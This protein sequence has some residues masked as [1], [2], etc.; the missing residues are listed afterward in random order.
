MI[1]NN[2]GLLLAIWAGLASAA[3]ADLH[4]ENESLSEV[5]KVVLGDIAKV[6][7]ILTPE[8]NAFTDKVTIS[9]AKLEPQQMI[10]QVSRLLSEVGFVFSHDQGVIIVKREDNETTPFVYFPK[11]RSVEY[12]T[13][14]VKTMLPVKPI[15]SFQSEPQKDSTAD[16]Q[17]KT[18]NKAKPS[19]PPQPVTKKPSTPDQ[20]VLMVPIKELAK[21]QR[22]ISHLDQPTGEVLLKAAIYEVSTTKTDGSAIQLALS[23]AG[24]QAQAGNILAGNWAKVA[25][26]AGDIKLDLVLSALDQDTRFKSIAKPHVR[27]KNGGEAKFSVGQDVPILAGNQLDR[28]GN[29]IQQV[30]YKPSGIIL[31]ARPEIRKESIE[32]ELHQELSNFVTTTTGINNSPTLIKRSVDT[33]LSLQSGELVVL[34]GLQDNK[35][36]GTQNRMPFFNW[37]IGDQQRK[38]Q[39]EILVFIE[40]IKL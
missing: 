25:A 15:S 11:H 34:A 18:E 14:I 33:Q 26:R 2:L 24:L 21:V 37:L 38:E 1:K 28:N 7:Y 5:A 22:L 32:L 36:D 13:S 30:E 31:R 35:E 12:L 19:E 17:D 6:P 20:L 29:A 27:V 8:A 16:K 23:V 4:L 39:T 3:P 10:H 40:A 9:L